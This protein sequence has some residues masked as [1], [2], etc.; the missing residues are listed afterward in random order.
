MKNT[1]ASIFKKS[2][3]TFYY[4]S[5]FFENE[6]KK[7]IF[8]L[9]AFVRT[10][11]DFV[12]QIPQDIEGF[13]KFR[14][15]VFRGL[16]GTHTNI[17]II[18]NFIK[19]A[20]KVSIEKYMIGEFISAMNQDLFKTRYST[21]KELK[22]YIHGSA[23]MIGLMLAKI[24]FLPT[25]SYK[26]AMLLGEALQLINFI[27]DIKEDLSLGRIY[28]PQE[29]LKKFNLENIYPKTKQEK[30]NFKKFLRF[31]IK[32][33][34]KILNKAEKGYKYI[35]KEYLIQIKVA[36][37]MY[38]WTAMQLESNPLLV[39]ERKI[40]PKP[41]QIIFALLRQRIINF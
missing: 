27:R 38:Q 7:D 32:R 35:P 12:D 6:I 26:S 14:K 16:K 34:K 11:D 3:S 1:A 9:Y 40:K 8:T 31:E 33:Y 39:F 15:N 41:Y 18:D 10:A 5:L 25:S 29:D 22:K 37:E 24:F 4:S 28:L 21:Y 17:E 19:L 36:S 20:K 30:I 2:S 23:S 13:K